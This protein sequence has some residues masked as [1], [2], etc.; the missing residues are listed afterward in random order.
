MNGV[1]KFVIGGVATSLMAMAAHSAVGNGFID[2]LQGKADAAVAAAGLPGVTAAM[3]RKPML[4]RNVVLSGDASEA[5]RERLT[6]ALRAIPG[7]GSISWADAPSSDAS[8]PDMAAAA[9]PEAPATPEAVTNCQ[10]DVDT[11][12]SGQT[13]QF[14]SGQASI[15]VESGA[16]LD[17]L[18]AAL[19]A[20]SGV[21][22]DV[23]GHTD[24]Q[25]NDA[26]NMALSEQR[27]ASVAAALVERGVP[28]DRL[29]VH[30]FGETQPKVAGDSA[31]AWAQNR[32]I[33]F[34]VASTAAGSEG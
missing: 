27:A 6:A 13:V 23:N 34:K 30:G 31:E 11:A 24:A 28:Q 25:G 8:G 7:I 19:K 17:A 26:A 14:D 4:N 16:L 21:T 15:K 22:V 3:V 29:V 33:E 9:A 1:T 5:D 10:G 32:R 20:C 2:S 12:I 18:A